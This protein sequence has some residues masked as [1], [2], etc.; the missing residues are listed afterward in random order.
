MDGLEAE[1]GMGLESIVEVLGSVVALIRSED[2]AADLASFGL[3]LLAVA[4]TAGKGAFARHEA[5]MQVHS[6]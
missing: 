4:L 3:E 6:G 2:D 1:T 5:L